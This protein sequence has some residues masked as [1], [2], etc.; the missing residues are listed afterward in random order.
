MQDGY[1]CELECSREQSYAAH[2][3]LPNILIEEE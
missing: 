3:E 1:E 2:P